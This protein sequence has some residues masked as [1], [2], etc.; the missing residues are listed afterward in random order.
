MERRKTY[1]VKEIFLTLQG[2]GFHSGRTAVFCRFSGCNF[3]NGKEKDRPSA[4]CTFCDTDFVGSDGQN[5]GKYTAEE[6]VKKITSLWPEGQSKR[7][8]VCT[9]GEPLLQLDDILIDELH[10]H[11]FEIAV[12][13]NGSVKAPHKIDWLTISPKSL[14][15][16]KQTRGDE[17]KLVYPQKKLDPELFSKM[18]FKHFYLQP[19]DGPMLDENTAVSISYCLQ[20]PQW[21]LSM[22]THKYLGID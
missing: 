21:K 6:L 11:S 20:H 3:W 1:Q 7:F 2:E 14:E 17:L 8:V 10:K 12:E 15:H 4:I 22:Q 18:D 16:F 5:G 19:M 13:S 9:G